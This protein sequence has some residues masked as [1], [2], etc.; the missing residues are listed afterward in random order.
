MIILYFCKSVEE[1]SLN[2]ID[3]ETMN[4]SIKLRWLQTFI[5]HEHYLWFTLPVYL[6]QVVGR[7]NFLLRCDFDP[8]SLPFKLSKFHMQVL[9]Y[10]KMLHKHNF[11]PH[12]A[13]IWKN[14]CI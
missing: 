9:L 14:R 12:E 2:V 4:G 5:K 6:F 13:T 7:I 1:G 3:L 11:S 8:L 10:W